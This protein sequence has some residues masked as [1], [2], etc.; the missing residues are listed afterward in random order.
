MEELKHGRGINIPNYD[1]KLHRSVEP[2]RVVIYSSSLAKY[3]KL[4]LHV[5]RIVTSQ[6]SSRSFKLQMQMILDYIFSN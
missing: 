5:V 1:F 3:F 4:M 6:L 2:A